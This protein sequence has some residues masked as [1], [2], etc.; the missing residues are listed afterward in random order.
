M[1]SLF[2]RVL[3]DAFDTL[4][5]QLRAIHSVTGR[6]TWRGEATITRGT[7]FLVPLFAAATQL[8]S[9]RANVPTSVEFVATDAG[10][11]AREQGA[12]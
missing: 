8:P 6:E 1:T 4:P 12:G 11:G 7:H 10:A 9:S 5:P 3:G 2:R